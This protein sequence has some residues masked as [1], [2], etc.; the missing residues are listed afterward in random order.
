MTK[1]ECHSYI[2]ASVVVCVDDIPKG[3]AITVYLSDKPTHLRLLAPNYF[4][5]LTTGLE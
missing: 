5:A 1:N 2:G 4:T 3:R